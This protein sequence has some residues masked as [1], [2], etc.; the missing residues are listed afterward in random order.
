MIGIN[1]N[2][3]TIPYADLIIDGLKLYETRNKDTLR[4]Y[5]GRRVAIVRTGTGKAQ[6]IGTV[7]IGKPIMVTQEQFR[8]LQTLHLVPEGSEFDIKPEG[9]KYL[10]PMLKPMR[11]AH[12]RPVGLGIIARQVLPLRGKNNC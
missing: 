10:Y 12:P 3:K 1:I 2:S 8:Q 4:P 9:T 6:A 5:V 11:F 7:A